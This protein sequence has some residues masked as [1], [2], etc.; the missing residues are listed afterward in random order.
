MKTASLNRYTAPLQAFWN[1]RNP[2]EQRL[3]GI[4]LTVAG[5]GLVYLLLIDPALQGREQLHKSLPGLRQ[6]VAELRVLA[7]EAEALPEPADSAAPDTPPL[8]R[9]SVEA[10]LQGK[11]LTPENLS[12]GAGTVRVQ[13][14]S[15]SFGSLIGWLDAMQSTHGLAVSEANIVAQAQ[16]DLVDA[17]LTLQKRNNE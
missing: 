2:R 14:A 12:V 16:A 17:T 7:Q 1:A 4:G 3:L 13:L 15:V 10:A 8:T 9:A 11:G 6:Q 5:L